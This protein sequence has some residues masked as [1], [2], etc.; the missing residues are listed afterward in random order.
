MVNQQPTLNQADIELLSKHFLTK[1]DGRNFATKD[2]LKHFTTKTD[3]AKEIKKIHRKL[4]IIIQS[5]DTD[6]LRL[7][8]RVNRIEK[9]LDLPRMPDS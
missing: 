9:H 7:Q 1:D 5:F 6:Y 3:L 2:D 8:K 4:D